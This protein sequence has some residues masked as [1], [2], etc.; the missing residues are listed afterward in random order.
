MSS[1]IWVLK[2]GQ[3]EDEWDHSFL[4]SQEK[5]LDKLASILEV[6]NLSDFYDYSNLSAQDGKNP[7]PN[8]IDSGEAIN[9]FSGLINAIK[10]GHP[11]FKS[12]YTHELLDELEDCLAKIT[13]ADK[14]KSPI[15]L[16][17]IP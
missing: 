11:Q 16:V 7:E 12:K 8:Y 13:A 14:K 3:N 5:H 6:K 17:V 9:S 2:E 4:L 15:R 10:E 1:T